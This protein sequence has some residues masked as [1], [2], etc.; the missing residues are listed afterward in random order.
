MSYLPNA[1]SALTNE[2][3]TTYTETY[4]CTVPDLFKIW[5]MH[6][7]LHPTNLLSLIVG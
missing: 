3:C 7:R 6:H 1:H 2:L 5:I 4:D